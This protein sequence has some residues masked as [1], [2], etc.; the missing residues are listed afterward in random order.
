[1]VADLASKH[2]SNTRLV[3]LHSRNA[4][5]RLPLSSTHCRLVRACSVPAPQ[6]TAVNTSRRSCLCS[7]LASYLN[8][9]YTF[10]YT[11][12]P[13]I[14][15]II[16]CVTQYLCWVTGIF[17]STEE[18]HYLF[19]SYRRTMNATEGL[20]SFTKLE[21]TLYYLPL[22]SICFLCTSTYKASSWC[23][24]IVHLT[25]FCL[26]FILSGSYFF[27]CNWIADAIGYSLMP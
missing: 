7:I 21:S 18:Y 26:Y 16:A 25:S 10:F 27:S 8:A 14:T 19:W 2:T 22:Q 3:T 23:D 24:P 20:W 15:E 17:C 13:T 11:L 9:V 1:M 12:P 6:C 5:W 4:N